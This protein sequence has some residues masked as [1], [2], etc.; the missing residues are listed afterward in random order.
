[1]AGGSSLDEKSLPIIITASHIY[2]YLICPHKVYLDEFGNKSCM[3]PESEL[4]SK[5]WERGLAHEQDVLVKLGLAISEV[6]GKDLEECEQETLRMMKKG[7]PLIYQGRLSAESMRGSPDLLEKVSGE[8]R[9]GSHYYFPIEMK[10]GSAYEDEESG[11]LK[12]HYVLQLFF[13]AD[14]LEKVQ[15]VRPKTAKIIDGEMRIVQV[16]LP[17]FEEEYSRCLSEIRDLLSGKIESEPCVGGTCGQ[18]HWRSFC[19]RW[20]T[21]RD[22]VSLVRKL[23]RPKRSALRKA[24]IKTVKE[25]AEV[26][27]AKNP[28]RV[29]GISGIALSQLVRRAAVIKQGEPI[30]HSQVR[31]P[32][33]TLEIFFDIETVPLENICY[34][35]GIVERRGAKQHYVSFFADSPDEEE[36]T[37]KAFWKY[38][39]D[40]KD[41]QVYYYTSYEKTVLTALSERYQ[42]DHQLF[43]RFFQN[44][45]DL[46]AIVDRCTEWPSHSYSIKIVSKLLGFE[47]SERDPG[48]LKAALWYMEYVSDPKANLALKERIIRYNKEDCEAMIVLKDWLA[49]K[50]RDLEEHH[51]AEEH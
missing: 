45:T 40:L 16:S 4:E 6:E 46:Y 17:Q 50:S 28:L 49:G 35:Y 30:L 23:N 2:D 8:S 5:L 22:D 32:E 39:A 7:L 9:L 38:A 19:Y 34:L 31:F 37:W 47:Y 33:R 10:S 21:E 42:F 48:G 12:E 24:G 11:R 44:S 27:R 25:L 14:V 36:S 3:D 18:C 43:E 51:G 26:A 41:F 20:A 15:G 13:Y 29:E 1:M